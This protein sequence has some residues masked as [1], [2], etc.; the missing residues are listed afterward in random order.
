LEGEF[1]YARTLYIGARKLI[2]KVNAK[3]VIEPIPDPSQNAMSQ[4]PDPKELIDEF[5][6]AAERYHA[7]RD[8][9]IDKLRTRQPSA[10]DL[11]LGFATLAAV[12]RADRDELPQPGQSA[13]DLAEK[14]LED[15]ICQSAD[16]FELRADLDVARDAWHKARSEQMQQPPGP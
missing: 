5:R 7:Q 9:E 6:A 8:S 1:I 2:P 15:M 12:L 3:P 4:Q 16:L 11:L 14:I 10:H 13:S